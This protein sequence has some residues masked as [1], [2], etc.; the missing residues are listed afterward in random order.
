MDSYFLLAFVRVDPALQRV[1]F[2]C[3]GNTHYETATYSTLSKEGGKDDKKFKDMM[4]MLG[5]GA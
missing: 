3:D 4:K 5:R 2:L 1:D